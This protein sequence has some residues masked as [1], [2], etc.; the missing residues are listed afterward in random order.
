[1][2]RID[3]T[4]IVAV[5]VG[6][7]FMSLVLILAAVSLGIDVA[8]RTDGT[9]LIPPLVLKLAFCGLAIGAGSVPWI[10]PFLPVLRWKR[11]KEE[12]TDSGSN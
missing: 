1:M 4:V 3:P 2:R 9:R 11:P 5:L 10:I 7:S 6:R 12:N 8:R